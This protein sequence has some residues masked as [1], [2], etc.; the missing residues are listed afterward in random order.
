[1]FWISCMFKIV[2]KL[3]QKKT[4]V[5]GFHNETFLGKNVIFKIGISTIR[6]KFEKESKISDEALHEDHNK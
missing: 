5:K 6:K 1:M 2:L 3:I 4:F